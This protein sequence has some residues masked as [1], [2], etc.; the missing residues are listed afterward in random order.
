M[1]REWV[2]YAVLPDGEVR[3]RAVVAA[4]S[5]AEAFAAH[6]GAAPEEM[7]SP[8][9]LP[10][11]LKDLWDEGYGEETEAEVSPLEAGVSC[12]PPFSGGSGLFPSHVPGVDLRAVAGEKANREGCGDA[13][14]SAP[15]PAEWT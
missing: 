6:W 4:S 9:R 7:T 5:A 12:K 1:E 10:L 13:G 2:C 11:S 14:G 8:S 15:P 3:E